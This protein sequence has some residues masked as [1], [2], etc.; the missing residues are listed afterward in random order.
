MQQ[1]N[2]L[3]S[4]TVFKIELLSSHVDSSQFLSSFSKACSKEERK[5]DFEKIFN[6]YDVVSTV[7]NRETNEAC[8][9]THTC[10]PKHQEIQDNSVENI[11]TM[12]GPQ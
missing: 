7:I 5:R 11:G 12:V 10:R 1:V 8:H 4:I 6:H 2:K 3:S 9:F